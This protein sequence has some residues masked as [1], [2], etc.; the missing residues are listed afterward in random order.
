MRNG[1]PLTISIPVGLD[2]RQDPLLDEL[3]G[4]RARRARW[5]LAPV[6]DEKRH[7]PGG[8]GGGFDLLDVVGRVEAADEDEGDW[9]VV[10]DNAFA[11]QKEGG[12]VGQGGFGRGADVYDCGVE[13]GVMV[14]LFFFN[15]CN[16]SRVV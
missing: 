5:E 3:G 2:S 4:R 1:L 10:V 16:V 9:F 15:K 12:D 7:G 14:N 8:V 13:A 11:W 6:G